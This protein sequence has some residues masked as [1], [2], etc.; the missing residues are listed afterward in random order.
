MPRGANAR[1]E[2]RMEAGRTGRSRRVEQGEEREDVVDLGIGGDVDRQEDDGEDPHRAVLLPRPAE[3]EAEEAGGPDRQRHDIECQ[4][5]LEQEGG[6]G[7]RRRATATE[8]PAAV[9]VP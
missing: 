7:V 2:T 8:R 4:A 3:Q 5:G 1:P 6:N 9:S